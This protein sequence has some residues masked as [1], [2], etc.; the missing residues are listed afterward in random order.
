MPSYRLLMLA[1]LVL[2][3][4]GISCSGRLPSPSQ[5]SPL[6]RGEPLQTPTDTRAFALQ[7]SGIDYRLEPLF[8]Y[9]I[10]GLVVS[11]HDSATWWDTIHADS[12]D[13]LN[14]ADL[15]L[16]WGANAAG[17]AYR[18]MYFHNGQFTCYFG[19][20]DDWP[21][22][23]ADTRAVSNNHLLTTDAAV[24]RAIR[25]LRVGDQVRLRGRLAN[26]SHNTG[27]PFHRS[28]SVTRDDAGCEI[29]LIDHLDLLGRGASWPRWLVWC[30][31]V[32]L[33]AGLV[34]WYRRPNSER[35]W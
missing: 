2:S 6:V 35:D 18:H 11:L 28:T 21:V 23:A 17:G 15:C 19:Y 9:D 4:A 3:G 10:A 33:L 27:F 12:N 29:I 7:S 30:G 8:D 25:R 24:A 31:V 22:R 16:V 20:A 32:L 14:V 26:Y 13:H 5:L 1:G 34:V